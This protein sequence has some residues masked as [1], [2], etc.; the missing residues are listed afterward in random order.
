MR[1]A[2]TF[3]AGLLLLAAMLIFS[4]LFTDHYPNATSWAVTAFLLVWLLATGFNM[5]VGVNKAG[6]SFAEELPILLV[7]F[8][9]P[10]VAAISLKWK[11]L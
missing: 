6:Y 3:T 9:I 11:V 1:M 10:A 2:M 8:L 5:W 4:K 7:L